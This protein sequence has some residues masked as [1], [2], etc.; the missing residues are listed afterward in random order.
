[1]NK[2]K[3]TKKSIKQSSR[4][5]TKRSNTPKSFA[6]YYIDHNKDIKYVR[7]RTIQNKDESIKIILTVVN[8]FKDASKFINT[9]SVKKHISLIQLKYPSC[10]FKYI[11][12]S[13]V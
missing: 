6:I 8:K 1:M 7:F 5:I 13:K 12:S 10:N 3:I 11:D 4:N 2:S 9:E